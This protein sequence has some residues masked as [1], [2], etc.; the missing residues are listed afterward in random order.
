MKLTTAFIIAFITA[1]TL[2]LDL[3]QFKSQLVTN[4]SVVGV[5]SQTSYEEH[6]GTFTLLADG[7]STA[8][9]TTTVHRVGL[10]IT[11]TIDAAGNERTATK[12]VLVYDK[13]GAN[14][15]VVDAA[16]QVKNY[17]SNEAAATPLEAAKLAVDASLGVNN[18]RFISLDTSTA[19]TVATIRRLDNNQK[20]AVTLAADGT[21]IVIEAE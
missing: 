17:S 15:K 9:T 5:S 14:E 16:P 4:G 21:P 7:S 12:D 19:G 1:S 6:L 2:A 18:W 10:L 3:E 8:T 11:R 13:D 20:I